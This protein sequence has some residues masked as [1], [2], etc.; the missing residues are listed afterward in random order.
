LSARVRAFASALALSACA[1]LGTVP[2]SLPVD[3]AALAAPFAA[4][5]RISARRGSDGVAGQ[6]AWTHDGARDEIAFATPLGQ[7]IARFHG[8]ADGVRAEMSD[9]RELRARDW[10]ELTA[11][12]LGFP[13]PVG[14]L[15]AWLRGLPRAGAPHT[16]ERD[17]EGRPALL[18]QDGWD[19]GYAYPDAAAR[20]PS[21]LTLRFPAGEPVEVRIVIDRIGDPP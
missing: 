11:E 3:D 17:A 16:L 19:V 9:G 18:R 20:R 15:S 6:F 7:T 8:D 14:G 13:L 5:G 10:D 21:R 4:E 12:A 2:E 1:Q